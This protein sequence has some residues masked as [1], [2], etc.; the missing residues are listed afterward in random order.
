MAIVW[1][2]YFNGALSINLSSIA[3]RV[4]MRLWMVDGIDLGAQQP[5][6]VFGDNLSGAVDGLAGRINGRLYTV[7]GYPGRQGALQF[8]PTA[9]L[10]VPE[11]LRVLKIA[12][13]RRYRPKNL[14]KCSSSALRLNCQ[15]VT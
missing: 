6:D 2:R 9:L 11:S 4:W 7:N 1:R 15:L 12:D 14:F 3:F 5:V 13:G 10:V 8:K